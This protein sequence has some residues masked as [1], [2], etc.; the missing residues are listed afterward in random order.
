[1]EAQIPLRHQ[2]MLPSRYVFSKTFCGCE[3]MMGQSALRY[4]HSTFCRSCRAQERPNVK[5]Q[6]GTSRAGSSQADPDRR[7]KHRIPPRLH[8]GSEPNRMKAVSRG[9]SSPPWLS[10]LSSGRQPG[11]MSIGIYTTYSTWTKV[12]RESAA[13]IFRP[14]R[15]LYDFASLLLKMTSLLPKREAVTPDMPLRLAAAAALAFPDGS[16]TASGLRREAARGRL[17]IER[18]AGKDYTTL[19]EHRTDEG[20]M[21]RRSKGARLW[22]RRRQGKVHPMGHPRSWSRSPHRGARR[23]YRHG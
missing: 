20:A 23:R 18:I 22:L 21:P 16:M 9:S 5:G 14:S 6:C 12:Q 17:V 7:C 1:M 10:F 3:K 4:F 15:I 11:I 8:T 2:V 13:R 19:G